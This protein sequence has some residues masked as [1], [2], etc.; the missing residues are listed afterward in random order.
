MSRNWI[1]IDGNEATASVAHRSNEVIAIYPI[2]PSSNMGEFADEWSAKGTTQR[3][4]RGARGHGDAVGGRRH[5]RGARRAAGRLAVDDVHGQ[6]GPAADDPESVQD[7]GRAD[8][9][10]H[11]R[12]G[13]H[14]RDPRAVDLRRSLRRHGHPPDRLL[15][16]VVRLGAGSARLRADRPGRHAAVAPPVRPLLRRVPHVAR[17][18]E[19]GGAHRRRHPGHAA[20]RADRRAPHARAE[21]GP[22]RRARHGAEP[23]RVLPGARGLQQLL[24]RLPRHRPGDDGRL[25]EAHRPPVPA[26]RLLRRARRRAGHRDHGL[27]RRDRGARPSTG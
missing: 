26:V 13:A 24:R 23:R 9:V 22:S 10:L 15:A 20:G 17:S 5:R 16:A 18:G 4:G 3:L 2:T 6:P 14:R 25:R 11:A 12:G 27:R 21:P 1:T 19:D 7:R 8:L